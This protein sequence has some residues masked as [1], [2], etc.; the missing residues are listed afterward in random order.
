ME[1]LQICQ[2]DIEKDIPIIKSWSKT[3]SSNP[4]FENIKHFILE[5]DTYFGLD[6]VIL[7]NY[8]FFHIGDDEKKFCLSIKNQENLTIGFILA[9]IF[10]LSI[11][12]PELI[13]QYIVLN[14]DYQNLGYGTQILN[15]I[16]TKSEQYF[17]CT[18][19]EAYANIEQENHAS[20]NLFK[21]F[22]FSFT[23]APFG[24]LRAHKTIK[25]LQEEKI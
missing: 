25:N 10:N 21:K 11:N 9:C 4:K 17:N 19:C 8:E 6:E 23:K 3:F 14:P 16:L 20:L 5:D 24:F 1:K 22:G 15:K 18:L 7:T 12:K 13:L 2:L